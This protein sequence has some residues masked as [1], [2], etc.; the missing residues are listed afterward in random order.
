MTAADT[1]EI[2]RT[3]ITIERDL[4]GEGKIDEEVEGNSDL[5]KMWD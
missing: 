5:F 1:A 4:L 2:I 3:S